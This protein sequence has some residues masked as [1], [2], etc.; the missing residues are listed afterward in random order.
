MSRY[1]IF[2]LFA[3][4]L[5]LSSLSVQADETEKV[6]IQ[7]KWFHQFQFAGY[8]AAKEKGFFA[9]EGLNVELIERDPALDNIEEVISGNAEYG[10]A[11]TG[12]L[13]SRLKGKPVVLLAQIFQHSPL[14]FLTLRRSGLRTP[15]DLLGKILM[16]EPS[17]NTDT[18][19]RAMVLNTLGALDK[20]NWEKH[21]Y[22]LEDLVDGRVDA[23]LAYISNEPAWYR[24]RG[25]E[26]NIIDPRDHGIDFYGDNLFT[27]ENEVRQNP[28]RAEKIRRASLKGWEYA[29]NNQEEII[30]LI[31]AKYNATSK[32]TREHLR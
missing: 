5:S 13:L 9:D 18:A 1:F 2:L 8:Y 28:E 31:L 23:I 27:T 24:A 17:G 3:L 26:V 11:D 7:L 20:V 6:R 19:L 4:C 30:D 25:E 22:R 32:G 16:S 14:V 15:Y 29:L 12:L 21:T 10:V